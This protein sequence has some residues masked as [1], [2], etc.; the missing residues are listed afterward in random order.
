MCLHVGEAEAG[1]GRAAAVEQASAKDGGVAEGGAEAG[2]VGGVQDFR[3]EGQGAPDAAGARRVLPVLRKRLND[4]DLQEQVN[5]VGG[6]VDLAQF[7]HIMTKKMKDCDVISEIKEAFKQL[8]SD[9]DRY[10]TKQELKDGLLTLVGRDLR[11][12]EVEEM[13]RE[14]DVDGDGKISQLDF[15]NVLN[16]IPKVESS[17]LRS[18]LADAGASDPARVEYDA[19]ATYGIHVARYARAAPGTAWHQAR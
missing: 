9:G 8:D 11:M 3:R 10:I 5:E 12:E 16:S 1:E 19:L 15:I 17:I 6:V 18:Y 7:V 4:A 2:A 13:L 14:A